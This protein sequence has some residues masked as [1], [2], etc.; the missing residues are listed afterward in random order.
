MIDKLELRTDYMKPE[1]IEALGNKYAHF[2]IGDKNYRNC[3]VFKLDK[4]HIVTIKTN[5]VFPNASY[6]SIE[7]NPSH[8][9]NLKNT[10][11]LI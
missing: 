7:L 6:C 8:F 1:A 5:P 2:M 11:E 3:H 10:N 4:K 9:K